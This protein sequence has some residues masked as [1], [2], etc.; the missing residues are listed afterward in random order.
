ML[1]LL[2]SLPNAVMA[3]NKYYTPTMSPDNFYVPWST[4]GLTAG[5]EYLKLGIG[6]AVIIGGLIF[7]FPYAVHF[8][9]YLVE[10]F[11]DKMK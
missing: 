9:N 6:A 1:N 8:V 4:E 11:F 3:A 10:N 2:V 5:L 7:L